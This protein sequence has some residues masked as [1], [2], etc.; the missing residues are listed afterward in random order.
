VLPEWYDVDDEETL[1]WL[2]EEL[3]GVSNRFA[4][5]GAAPFTRA[6]IAAMPEI[7]Q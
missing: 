1:R 3:A 4:D 6:Y 2:R 5:G 7:G